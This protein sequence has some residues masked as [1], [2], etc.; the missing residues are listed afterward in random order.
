MD[1]NIMDL[2]RWLSALNWRISSDTLIWMPSLLST[3]KL[4]QKSVAKSEITSHDCLCC[5]KEMRVSRWPFFAPWVIMKATWSNCPASFGPDSS[6]FWWCPLPQPAFLSSSS[7]ET[8][9]APQEWSLP[10]SSQAHSEE[11]A[12][13]VFFM[14][15]SILTLHF[16]P[17]TRITQGLLLVNGCVTGKCGGKLACCGPWKFPGTRG[18]GPGLLLVQKLGAVKFCHFTI[19][20]VLAVIYF[21]HGAEGNE[22][23]CI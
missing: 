5:Q 16:L 10:S 1:I 3:R 23:Y 17:L 14:S 15:S 22:L 21:W 13:Y 8:K 11:R 12:A 6:V 18:T 20:D 7:L 9:T 2:R 4:H 19:F